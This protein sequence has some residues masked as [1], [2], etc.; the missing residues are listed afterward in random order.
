MKLHTQLFSQDVRDALADTKLA[1][2][3]TDDVEFVQF[4][5]R[6]SRSHLH[7]FLIQLGTYDQH[8]G[9]ANSRH[10]KNSGQYGA[11]SEYF[12]GENIWAATYDEWGW[13]IARIFA[14][15]PEARFGH[16][17]DRDDFNRQTGYKYT[18]SESV[19]N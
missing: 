12:Q 13:F 14:L 5:P 1:G 11:T 9:P 4:T 17:R 16:Y 19:I 18:I 2:Q 10:Y 15:D 7:G 6:G 3:M 8:S